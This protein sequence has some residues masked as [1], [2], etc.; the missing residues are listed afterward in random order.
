M[1]CHLYKI[2]MPQYVKHNHVYPL[3]SW[4]KGEV[5]EARPVVATGT[6]TLVGSSEDVKVWLTQRLGWL[7]LHWG[8]KSF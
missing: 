8:S 5:E 6:A 3:Y 1:I 7:E 4:C 2:L